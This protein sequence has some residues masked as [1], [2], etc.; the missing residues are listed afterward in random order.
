MKSKIL[1]IIAL[2]SLLGNFSRAQKSSQI[3]ADF[4]V[5][6]L[7]ND[8]WSG[9][10]ADPNA[11]K[12]DGPF[13]T[14]SRAKRSVK[15]FKQGVYRD[16]FVMIRG[17]QYRL[18]ETETFTSDDGHYDSYKINYMAYPGEEPVFHSDNEISGWKLAGDVP[19][20][21]DAAK[22]KVYVAKMPKLPCDYV[23]A[24][25]IEFAK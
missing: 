6:T 7:G 13:A 23:L 11:N 16:I 12:T 8:A 25:K 2:L 19:G 14:F 9:K 3:F 1:L 15:F 18:S 22:G 5:S 4:Y 21:P 10:L 24:F 20:M 17:G